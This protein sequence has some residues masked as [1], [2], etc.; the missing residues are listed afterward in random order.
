LTGVGPVGAAGVVIAGI[1]VMVTVL[2][3]PVLVGAQL[4]GEVTIQ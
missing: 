4:A 1:T 2:E 3:V